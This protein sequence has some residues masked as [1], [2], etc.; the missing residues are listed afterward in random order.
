[1]PWWVRW[2]KSDWSIA[3]ERFEDLGFAKEAHDAI[4]A[5]GVIVWVDDADG[6]TL[7]DDDLS[8]IQT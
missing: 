4:E 6:N 2:R 8:S 5:S 7:L 1:M 3:E